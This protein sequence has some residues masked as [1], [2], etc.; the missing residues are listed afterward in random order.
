[1]SQQ[2]SRNNGKTT[3]VGTWSQPIKNMEEIGVSFS[4][5]IVNIEI[6]ETVK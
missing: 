2:E 5:E 4:N 1:M 3:P 6:R